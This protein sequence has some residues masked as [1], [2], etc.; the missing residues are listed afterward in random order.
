M[1]RQLIYPEGSWV[2]LIT[3]FD[4]KGDLDIAGFK[5]LVDSRRP[6]ARTACCSWALRVSPPV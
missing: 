4:K 1:T 5:K 2:A 6:M 3:P